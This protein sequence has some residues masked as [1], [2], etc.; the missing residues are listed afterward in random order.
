MRCE[1]KHPEH[2][3]IHGFSDL[4]FSGC[5]DFL[6]KT[7]AG[8]ES[9]RRVEIKKRIWNLHRMGQNLDIATDNI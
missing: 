8:A 1:E 9:R 4:D 3:E 6:F 5:F 2:S 7:W